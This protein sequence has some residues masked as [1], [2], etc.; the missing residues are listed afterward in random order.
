MKTKDELYTWGGSYAFRLTGSGLHEDT[1]RI[2]SNYRKQEQM[3]KLVFPTLCITYADATFQ[4]S[5]GGEQENYPASRAYGLA[6][7]DPSVELVGERDIEKFTY[8]R[9]AHRVVIGPRETTIEFPSWNE[10][11]VPRLRIDQKKP[12]DVVLYVPDTLISVDAPLRISALQYADGRHIGG[13]RLEKRHPEW[14]PSVV[15]ETYD[16]RLR[17]IDGVTLQPLPKVMVDIRHWSNE[18]STPYGTGGFRLDERRYTDETGSIYLPG[19]PSGDLEAY[20]VRLPG[21]RAVVR[22]LRPLAGQNVRLHMRVWP[23]IK[24]TRRYRWQDGDT[25]DGMAQLTGHSIEEI[26]SL[27]RL[28]E[29]S[30][31]RPGMSILLPCF[32]ATYRMEQWDSFDWVGKSFG[33]RD[34]AGLTEVNGFRDVASLDGGMDIKLPDWHF[35]YARENDTLESID[36]LFGFPRRS[37]IVVGRAYHP[38]PRLP[39]AGETVAVPTPRFAERAKGR[40]KI[41]VK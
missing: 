40:K 9:G 1:L 22:C 30:E 16:L 36:T 7:F 17:V 18:I 20:I 6:Y 33:Y 4:N 34:A 21:R 10:L 19:R 23:L 25:F 29:V 41:S 37:T 11:V 5:I 3:L 2:R 13:V 27:N 38:D 32:A 12:V 26:L 14:Q 39:Y 24:D 31:L 28:K 15:K 35:F 8:I